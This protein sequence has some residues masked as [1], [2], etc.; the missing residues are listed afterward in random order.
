MKIL[1]F[2]ATILVVLAACIIIIRIVIIK[3]RKKYVILEVNGKYV[4]M[5]ESGRYLYID[6]NTGLLMGGI[7]DEYMLLD[8][9]EEAKRIIDEYNK[10]MQ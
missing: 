4:P 5:I 9:E 1:I 8:T 7:G 2:S 6:T 3:R 10:Q